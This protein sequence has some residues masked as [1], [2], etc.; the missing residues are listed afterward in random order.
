MV[1]FTRTYPVCRFFIPYSV[2]PD[3]IA[4]T[5]LPLIFRWHTALKNAMGF[6]PGKKAVASGMNTVVIYLVITGNKS[7]KIARIRE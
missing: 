1:V 3:W 4:T 7:A 2:F 6:F 5:I